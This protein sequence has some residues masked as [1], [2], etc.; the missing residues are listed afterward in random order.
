[1]GKRIKRHDVIRDIIREHRIRTQRGLA[2]HLQAAGFDCTQATISRDIADMGLIKSRDGFYELPED[3][4][5]QRM[6]SDMV[7]EVYTAG[8]MVI[9]KTFSGGAAGVAGAI[10]KAGVLGSLG[11]VAGDN[12]IMIAAR[13]PEDAI[14]I[15]G[16]LNALRNCEK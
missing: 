4:R 14:S 16:E 15:E 13:S 3:M 8:N 11:T 1:M 5:L 7:E 10:D 12:T 2:E 6:V 9:V